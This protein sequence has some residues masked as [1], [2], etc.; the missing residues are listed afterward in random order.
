MRT[1]DGVTSGV[2]RMLSEG[3]GNPPPINS[4]LT[5]TTSPISVPDMLSLLPGH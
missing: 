2:Q 4:A 3:E 5:P 1:P